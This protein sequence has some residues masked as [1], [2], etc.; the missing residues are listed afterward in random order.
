MSL[1]VVGSVA[2]DSVKT[3][4]GEVTDALGGSATYFSMAARL[5]SAVSV[6]GVVGQD[7]PEEHI[8]LLKS[9]GID[10]SGIQFAE[11]KTFRWAGAYDGDMSVAE[12]LDTQLN[13]FADF[14]PQLSSEA[15]E[16]EF[17][18][19]ANI[20]PSLQRRVLE[21]VTGA[22]LTFCDTMNLWI[23]TQLDEVK[24]L[25]E[26]V[27]GIILNDQEGRMLTG[28]ANLVR[29]G[30]TIIDMG[31]RLVVIKKGEHGA[32]LISEDDVIPLPAYPLSEVVDPTGA[33]DSFAGGLMGYLAESGEA[34]LD[35]LKAAV[36][37]GIV[38]SSFC[39]EAFS[40]DRLKD[41]SRDDIDSRLRL[42][43]DKLVF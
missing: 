22:K 21:Q 19:L 27:T 9:H 13:V 42:F 7:F 8:G 11:G 6:V 10:V 25:L 17:L 33:G 40:L 26:G 35:T 30:R 16:T 2:L 24:K 41:V 34:S 29:A 4:A 32:L 28:E 5:F 23:E 3:P 20:H 15:K 31:P 37:H 14:D 43:R 36:A 39:C 18:F 12:T 1:L 38:T